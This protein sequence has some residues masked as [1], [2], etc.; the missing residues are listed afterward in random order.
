MAPF[1]LVLTLLGLLLGLAVAEVLGGFSRALKLTRS[2]EAT[3]RIGWLTPLLGLF[4]IIDLTGFWS[5][6]Y[7]FR[8]RLVGDHLTLLAVLAIIGTY[9]L[10]CTL[11]FPAKPEEWPDFAPGTSD[12]NG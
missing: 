2:A 10:A 7:L 9:Y 8:D 3:V 4:V 6:G 12:R 5:I 11:I 1:D